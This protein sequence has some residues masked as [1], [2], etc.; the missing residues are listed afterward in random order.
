MVENL[1]EIL[2]QGFD[3]I[4]DQFLL[5][6]ALPFFLRHPDKNRIVDILSS[7]IKDQSIEKRRWAIKISAE[8]LKTSLNIKLLEA[9]RECLLRP[10]SDLNIR[11]E[12]L[13][14]FEVFSDDQFGIVLSLLLESYDKK[15][16]AKVKSL[17][18]SGI[19]KVFS[20]ACESASVLTKFIAVAEGKSR[21]SLMFVRMI[22]E[23]LNEFQRN[24]IIMNLIRIL[25]SDPENAFVVEILSK[26]LPIVS[27]DLFEGINDNLTEY[28]SRLEDRLIP[29]K[30]M[31]SLLAPLLVLQ[32]LPQSFFTEERSEFKPFLFDLIYGVDKAFSSITKLSCE[33]LPKYSNFVEYSME[34]VGRKIFND[35][36]F[37]YM[38]CVASSMKRYSF[39][40][41][42]NVDL[43]VLMNKQ[44]LISGVIE[45]Y[46]LLLVA[47]FDNY[48][49]QSGISEVEEAM[50]E[51]EG[52]NVV[53]QLNKA[54]F[55]L[56]ANLAPFNSKDSKDIP[57]SFT[58]LL[59]ANMWT[60]A[61]RKMN[62][63]VFTEKKWQVLSKDMI[64]QLCHSILR[65]V[66]TC[67][68][69]AV[70]YSGVLQL[71]TG[72]SFKNQNDFTNAEIQIQ[73]LFVLVGKFPKETI[74]KQE[75][76]K[77]FAWLQSNMDPLMKH[78][79]CWV[80]LVDSMKELDY[81]DMKPELQQIVRI[82]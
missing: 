65:S 7:R 35:E 77:L 20:H 62:D 73:V 11:N 61:L 74:L 70:C 49:I 52:E 41:K 30:E 10:D 71:L 58:L 15:A 42:L 19:R 29:G 12:I 27:E 6:S 64:S 63:Q 43:H 46:S 4:A 40:S 39:I 14:I 60:S 69:D 59:L 28:I 2:D 44:S 16:D 38:C 5:E 78:K 82:L 1:V 13:G 66:N 21:F 36:K 37:I 55:N 17:I 23:D 75:I 47:W 50:E 51:F 68:I 34:R 24:A 48:G 56:D 25:F 81:R 54:L 9:I 67:D 33:I 31:F 79:H 80:S 18:E 76:V 26:V 45:L 53:R 22:S 32:M 57:D 8:F 3:A 72:I